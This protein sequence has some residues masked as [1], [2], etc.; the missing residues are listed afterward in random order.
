MGTIRKF[1]D[2]LSNSIFVN[3]K[4]IFCNTETVNESLICPVCEKKL[5]A[6]NG[7][8][9]NKCGAKLETSENGCY[10]C[11]DKNYIFDKH[12]SCFIY[13]DISATPVKLLKYSEKKYLTEPM[14]KIMYAFHKELFNNVDFITYVPMTF[15]RM[16]SRGYN[17][18]EV[19][20]NELSSISKVPCLELLTKEHE[21]EHQAN[22][23]FNGRIKNLKGSFVINSEYLDI[24]KNKNILIIDDV[25]TTGSTIHECARVLLKGKANG[26]SALTF[27]KTDP[28]GQYDDLPF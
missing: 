20:A 16:K 25:F 9:C 23:D 4:C 15:D 10:T 7:S 6:L 26:V 5:K 1:L 14:A 24:V 3:Y 18:C 13:D 21:T 28:F 12:R 11:F 17:Q 8:V 27:V 2:M 19:L 22:L